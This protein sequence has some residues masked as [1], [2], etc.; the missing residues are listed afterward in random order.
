MLDRLPD[1]L[2][3]LIVECLDVIE[4]I[5][6]FRLINRHTAAITRLPVIWARLCSRYDIKLP[7]I[8]AIKPG[9]EHRVVSIARLDDGLVA[10]EHSF[11]SAITIPLDGEYP[12]SV[13]ASSGGKH[14][15]VACREGLAVVDVEDR[16]CRLLSIGPTGY[17]QP[18]CTTMRGSGDDEK[19]VVAYETSFVVRFLALTPLLVIDRHAPLATYF[20]VAAKQELT[21]VNYS[22]S[23][24]VH[25]HDP[26]GL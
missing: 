4:L 25:G 21:Y 23:M 8:T 17:D 9:Q 5:R 15:V 24:S 7:S 13:L 16:T 2:L 18:L 12:S 6:T 26:N 14:A 19:L 10:S 11:Q 22:T 3:I 1:D 20:S